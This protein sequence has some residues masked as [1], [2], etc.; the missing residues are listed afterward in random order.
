MEEG[1]A[2]HSSILAWRIPM[3][4]GAW[5][6]QS[7]GSR[8]VRHDCA[9]ITSTQT[10]LAPNSHYVRV[11]KSTQ[12]I[13]CLCHLGCDCLLHQS[14]ST[15][16]PRTR[17]T[18]LWIQRGCWSAESL[19]SGWNGPVSDFTEPWFRR[20]GGGAQIMAPFSKSAFPVR[21]EHVLTFIYPGHG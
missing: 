8:R 16:K 10:S 12:A 1:M 21:K 13:H 14:G 7:M 17:Q 9:T 18:R 2:M 15:S 11:F 19:L 4:R 20:S 3:D 6:L 5:Q